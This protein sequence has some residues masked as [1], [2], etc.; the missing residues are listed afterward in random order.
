MS[1]SEC[2][3]C[4]DKLKDKAFDILWNGTPSLGVYFKFLDD[5]TV[6]SNQSMFNGQPWEVVNRNQFALSRK[7]GSLVLW[8]FKDD[9]GQEA[10]RTDKKLYGMKLKKK[11]EGSKR[12]GAMN[13][14]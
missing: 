4:E 5:G 11:M 1:S 9:T 7:N 2:A 12:E 10:F 13:H 8:E 6:E 14:G 3:R